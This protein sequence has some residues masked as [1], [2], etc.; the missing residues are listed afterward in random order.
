MAGEHVW[1]NKLE[2]AD[3]LSTVWSLGMHEHVTL[4]PPD[5]RGP[6]ARAI[7]AGFPDDLLSQ[8]AERLLH[9]AYVRGESAWMENL[10][11]RPQVSPQGVR[12]PRT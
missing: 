1:Q 2:I 6:A 12:A 9:N 11:T 3:N 7:S 4:M 10:L 5:A 8:S